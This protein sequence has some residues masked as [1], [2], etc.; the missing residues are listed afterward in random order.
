MEG[1]DQSQQVHVEI[2]ANNPFAVHEYLTKLYKDNKLDLASMQGRDSNIPV[3]EWMEKCHPD[4]FTV[5]PQNPRLL[6]EFADDSEKTVLLY[7]QYWLFLF[8]VRNIITMDSSVTPE[9]VISL[10]KSISNLEDQGFD[11]RFM[12]TEML[13][14]ADT[15]MCQYE[16]TLAEKRVIEKRKQKVEKAFESMKGGPGESSNKMTTE[17]NQGSN[18]TLEGSLPCKTKGKDLFKL[19]EDRHEKIIAWKGDEEKRLFQVVQLIHQLL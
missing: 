6:N 2:D 13:I 17:E 1:S 9:Y 3:K 8:E 15:L 4:I 10:G 18:F 5:F 11:C 7:S 14:V 12:R 16:A 19:I